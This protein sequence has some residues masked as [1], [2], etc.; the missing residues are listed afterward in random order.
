MKQHILECLANYRETHKQEIAEY[1]QAHKQEILEYKAEYRE[2]HKQEIT[3]QS[4]KY[5]ETHKQEIAERKAEKIVCDCGS[6]V[7]RGHIARHKKTNKHL[8]LITEQ[9]NCMTNPCI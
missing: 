4:A 9:N 1:Y 5:R 6:I 8:Q 2:T 7:R 3:E